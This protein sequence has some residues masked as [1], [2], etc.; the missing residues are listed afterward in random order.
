MRFEDFS[1]GR[2][3]QQYQYKSFSPSPV[4]QEWT[5]GD[6]RIHTLLEQAAAAL[7]ALNAF[8]LIVP[9]IDRFIYM[10]VVKEANTSSR[11]EGTRTEMEDV[12]LDVEFV[13]EEKKDDRQEVRNYIEAMN[14]AIEELER[15]PL[16]SRLLRQTH[17]TLL[18]GVRGEHKTPGDFRR[19]QNWIGG[20]SLQDAVFIPPHHDEVPG[21]MGD[22]EQ[23]W[24]N[25]NIQVPDLIRIAISHYQFETI[26]P[27]LD[28]NGRIGRLLI[29]LYLISKG[30]LKKPS[31]YLSAY[32]ERHKGRYYDALTVVRSSNDLGHWVRFFLLA[33]RETAKKGV[34][35]FQA[36]MQLREKANNQ[37]LRLGGRARNGLLLLEKLYLSPIL[38]VQQAAALIGSS[39]PTANSLVAEFCR[40]GLLKELTGQKRNRLFYFEE[41]Y[42]LFL[43]S[44]SG[45][46]TEE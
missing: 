28:G 16:S 41:Y 30:L 44:V 43:D 24:H 37:V 40:L 27:F 31:L 13:A 36:I 45:A 21:L 33:V 25:E 15:L 39:Q 20:A 4:N 19:S 3:V 26:H 12:L 42:D 2:Y 10:H 22:L 1:A 11:I 18:R 46:E 9:D 29:T 6:A 23:F 5:W 8:S 38:T 34:E 7:A 14:S 32:I 17:G 35:T